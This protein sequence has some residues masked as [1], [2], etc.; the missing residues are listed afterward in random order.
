MKKA[1]AILAVAATSATFATASSAQG[2]YIFGDLGRS[3]FD[4]GSASGISVD[5]TDTM[6]GVGMGYSFNDYFS[7]ELGYVDLGETT[8]ST[9]A[10]VSGSL[11]GSSV[12]IDGRISVDA[13]GVFFGVRGDLPV[14]ESVDLFARAGMLHW[15]SDADFSG[16]ITIDGDTFSGGASAE[17][18]DGTDPYIG[19][20]ASYSFNENVSVN[21]QWNRYMLDVVDE[22]LDIDTLSIGLAYRF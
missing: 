15:Q 9:N 2:I 4:T 13:T 10:P 7:A 22:D 6:Y 12:T 20:G 8:A 17:L 18:D 21:A 16:T 19:L 11:Y 5:E 3:D 14:T 1:L